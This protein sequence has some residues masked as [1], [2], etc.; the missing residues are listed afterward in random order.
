MPKARILAI[1]DQLYF[2]S[3]V[4]GL[5][6]EAGYA[7]RAVANE[8]RAL[9]AATRD[10]T[11]DVLIADPAQLGKELDAALGR[12]RARWPKIAWLAV[13][14]DAAA[15]ATA[16]RAGARDFLQK[17]VDREALL[18]ALQALLAPPRNEAEQGRLL[19][20]NVQ[21]MSRV[22][23]LERMSALFEP[24]A[25]VEVEKRIAQLLGV[26][27]RARD[28][29]LYST[30]RSDGTVARSFYL[31]GGAEPAP[32]VFVFEP[33]ARADALRAGKLVPEPSEA[34]ARLVWLPF[35]REGRLLAVARLAGSSDGFGPRELESCRQI[36]GPG[37]LAL[38][39]ASDRESLARSS[40]RES[41]TGLPGRDFLD[42]VGRT[43]V[44]KAHR[45]GRRLSLLCVDVEGFDP[46][47]NGAV[48]PSLVSAITRTLRTTD[49]LVAEGG[50][51]FW[52]LVTDTDPL[53]GV[54]LKRRIAQRLRDSLREGNVD[55]NPAL[56]VAN[57]PVDGET[58]EQLSTAAER[59]VQEEHASVVRELGI[60]AETPL[61]AM[62][63][64]LLDRALWLPNDFVGEAAELLIGD[65]ACR[66]RDRGLLFLAPGPDRKRFL[67]PL[68][69]LGDIETA[70]EVFLAT[71]GD[72]VPS[73]PAVTALSLPPNVSADTS[74]IVRFGEGPP[75]ALVAGKPRSDG[76]RPVFHSA[77]PVLVEHM[78]FRLRAETGF[79]VRA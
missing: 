54:V 53:G 21:L 9:E 41:L 38:D 23:L 46:V 22:S 8:A 47:K 66:P 65:L 63:A 44:H 1:D 76:A 78:T 13:S 43:E 2:R 77:D 36:A 60:E 67:A 29:A 3:F 71:D 32:E 73:G 58:L 17:P 7:V 49:V 26:E 12:L 30:P 75:Y 4:E 33:P 6:S 14:T 42:E 72:T 40:L 34:Q 27:T 61:S 45:F 79:G 56:G 70:T 64:R 62:G 59:R 18:R 50:K 74:W 37:A 39:V 51:R 69:A 20:E 19:D 24:R 5:L 28:I 11:P 31:S 35:A 10:G 57:F 48:L 52:V 16:T 55:A 15:R 68:A 25:R